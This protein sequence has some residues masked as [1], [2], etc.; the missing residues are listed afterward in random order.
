MET[1]AVDTFGKPLGQLDM[2]M[3]VVA[4]SSRDADDD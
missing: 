4:G 3:N 2:M 1:L